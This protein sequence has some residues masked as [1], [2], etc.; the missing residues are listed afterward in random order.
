MIEVW[1]LEYASFDVGRMDW[2]PMVMTFL[3][4]GAT[5]RQANAWKQVKSIKCARV[6]GPHQHQMSDA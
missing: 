6:T 3:D 1:H 5:T 4:E 2:Q